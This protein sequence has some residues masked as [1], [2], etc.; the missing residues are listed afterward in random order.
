M[1]TTLQLVRT[2]P[3]VAWK[4][5]ELTRKLLQPMERLC[6]RPAL[7][8]RPADCSSSCCI[9]NDEDVEAELLAFCAYAYHISHDR[10][11]EKLKPDDHEN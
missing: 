2:E 3:Q 10:A 7:P 1:A 9:A 5:R 4:K 6:L 11:P 8:Q